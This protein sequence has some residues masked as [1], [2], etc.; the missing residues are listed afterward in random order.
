MLRGSRQIV[1]RKSSVSGVSPA[2]Y[3]EVTRKLATSPT[4]PRGSYGETGPSG[5]WALLRLWRQPVY[6]CPG[7]YV[8]VLTYL[9]DRVMTFIAVTWHSAAAI[10]TTELQ[11]QHIHVTRAAGHNQSHRP[12]FLR[13]SYTLPKGKIKRRRK[14]SR[15]EGS[16]FCDTVYC[17]KM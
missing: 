1:T 14:V 12:S 11:L 10:S 3:E 15:P 2:C 6:K 7:L 13:F 4:S 8:Y 9:L 17:L 5:I 16:G